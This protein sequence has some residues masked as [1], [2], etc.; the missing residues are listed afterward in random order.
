MGSEFNSFQTAISL[1][2][3]S[4]HAKPNCESPEAYHMQHRPIAYLFVTI[5]INP[6]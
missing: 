3:C 2:L 5:D 6:L 1:S 4:Y